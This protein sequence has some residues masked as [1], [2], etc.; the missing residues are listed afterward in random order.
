MKINELF[1]KLIGEATEFVGRC[2]FLKKQYNE[3]REIEK[4]AMIWDDCKVFVDEKE[5]EDVDSIE[6]I[7]TIIPPFNDPLKEESYS[8]LEI[9]TKKKKEE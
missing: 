7:Y 3:N 8:T 5:I 1:D 4:G 2:K 6:F 9:K